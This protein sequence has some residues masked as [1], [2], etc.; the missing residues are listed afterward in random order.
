MNSEPMWTR[1]LRA[2]VRA[3]R[4]YGHARS[5]AGAAGR[6]GLCGIVLCVG[7]ARRLIRQ[8]RKIPRRGFTPCRGKMRPRK[9]FCLPPGCDG[10]FRSGFVYWCQT[11][12]KEDGS[13][14]KL[15][16]VI[17][18]LLIMLLLCS[19]ARAVRMTAPT[20]PIQMQKPPATQE[21]LPYV[22]LLRTDP[23]PLSRAGLPAET[24][25]A[26]TSSCI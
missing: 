17:F 18:T 5:G 15:R 12:A 9:V 23:R 6:C 7:T 26:C 10:F 2:A 19:A 1:S 21:V 11:K 13:V 24:G 20:R 3:A 16:F 25:C 4:R 22:S 14:K 8:T